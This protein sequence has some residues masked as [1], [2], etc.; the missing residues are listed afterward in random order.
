MRK[1]YFQ[2]SKVSKLM[3]QIS[4]VFL[5]CMCLSLGLTSCDSS[6]D[7]KEVQVA[8]NDFVQVVSG[9]TF[10]IAG[11]QVDIT[12]LIASVAADAK[13][14]FP[15]DY[16]VKNRKDVYYTDYVMDHNP[17]TKVYTLDKI[18]GTYTAYGNGYE[19]NIIY[20]H[21]NHAYV[22]FFMKEGGMWIN[23][24]KR[25]RMATPT[26]TESYMMDITLKQL[27]DN[28]IELTMGYP[29]SVKEILVQQLID[30]GEM[31]REKALASYESSLKK[32]YIH[33][34]YTNKS[35]HSFVFCSHI[36][37]PDPE[38]RA[39]YN[40]NE[41]APYANDFWVMQYAI[42]NRNNTSI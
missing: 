12:E 28:S 35:A 13:A 18:N 42:H 7:P 37:N 24:T 32:E 8:P 39:Y 41:D 27:E 31:T 17:C 26:P 30:W 21:E 3:R 33:I 16:V 23:A 6:D 4:P 36:T 14:H 9:N 1:N 5:L 20:I 10:E 22:Y 15:T 29:A 11:Q 38:Q 34:Y 40:V 25:T 19:I 2:L